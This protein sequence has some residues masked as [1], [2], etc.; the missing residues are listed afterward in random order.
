[1]NRP[2]LCSCFQE[3]NFGI[4]I[5]IVRVMMPINLWREKSYIYVIDLHHE[6]NTCS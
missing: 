2:V 3:A 5:G 4:L 1:M 6:N